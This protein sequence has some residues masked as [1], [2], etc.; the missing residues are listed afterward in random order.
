MVSQLAQKEEYFTYADYLTWDD[1]VQYELID[2]IAY[3]LAAPTVFHQNIL[4][5]LSIQLNSFLKDKK[6]RLYLSPLDVRLNADTLD[7]TVVQPDL[8]VTCDKSKF[9]DKSYKGAP[10]L[11]IEILSPS[12]A[13]NDKV[14]KYHK[15]LLA[16]VKEYWIV[17]P[18]SKSVAVFVLENDRYISN[19]YEETDKMPSH[20]LDGCII[21]LTEVFAE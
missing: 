10:D 3:A 19:A 7:D 12:T 20:V 1:E 4:N 14:R 17:D 18:D 6:C 15:Y 16:G 5:N 9:D 8:F 2:G 13:L 11:V 21:D